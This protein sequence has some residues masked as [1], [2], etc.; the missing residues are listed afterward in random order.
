MPVDVEVTLK[1]G[2]KKV[3]TIPLVS[4]YGFKTDPSYEAKPAWPWTRTDYELFIPLSLEDIDIIVLDPFQE[5]G[6]AF[7][8]NN[9]WVKEEN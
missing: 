3:Y 4:M 7:P 5:S 1:D 6:D 8:S 2:M 9:R